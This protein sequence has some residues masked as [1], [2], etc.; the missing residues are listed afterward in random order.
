M[1]DPDHAKN[2]RAQWLYVTAAS[3]DEAKTIAKA[4]VTERLVAC[5]NILGDIQSVYWWEGAVQEGTE[6][7]MI[8]KTRKSRVKQAT[9]RIVELHSYECPCVVVLDIADGHPDYLKWIFKE[10]QQ[11]TDKS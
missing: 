2:E 5:A 3:T 11:H 4:L 7:A 6:V 10:T 1:P 9:R 8:L